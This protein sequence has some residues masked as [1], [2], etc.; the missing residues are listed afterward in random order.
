MTDTPVANLDELDA[1][2]TRWHEAG[3]NAAAWSEIELKLRNQIFAMMF[4]NPER[5]TNKARINHGMALVGDYRIN[6]KIDKAALEATRS[7]ISPAIFDAVISYR[8][9]VKAGGWNKLGEDDKKLFGPVI[10]ETPG[11]PGLEIKDA[12]KMRW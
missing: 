12:S 3:K 10:T 8:P 5:G 4:P 6:Y 11:T 2:L 9:E 1:L 7:I